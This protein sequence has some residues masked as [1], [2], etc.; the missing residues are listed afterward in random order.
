MNT[1]PTPE[2][3][4][5]ALKGAYFKDAADYPETKGKQLVHIDDARK[6]ERERDEAKEQLEAMRTVIKQAYRALEVVSDCNLA[7][8]ERKMVNEALDNLLPFLKL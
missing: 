1:R 2:T 7:F 5:A 4:A 8:D 6:L 3:D